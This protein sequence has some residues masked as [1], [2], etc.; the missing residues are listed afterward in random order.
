M[1]LC[2]KVEVDDMMINRIWKDLQLPDGLWRKEKPTIKARRDF[3]SPLK[4]VKVA[5][6]AYTSF[7]S[8]IKDGFHHAESSILYETAYYFCAY[9]SIISKL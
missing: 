1:Y 3:G 9:S 8:M 7:T 2:R 5:C 6:T 4:F